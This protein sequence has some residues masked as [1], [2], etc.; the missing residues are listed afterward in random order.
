MTDAAAPALVLRNRMIVARDGVR[1]A[2]DVYLPP[3]GGG[4]WPVLLERTPYGKTVDSNF[5]H[6]AADKTLMNRAQVA[7][8]FVDHGYAVAYQ[9]CRGRYDS[10]GVFVKYVNEPNDGYDTCAWLVAQDW[11]KGRIGTFGLSYAAHT[12]VHLASA[13]APGLAAMVVDSGGFSNAYQGGV[14]Q[15]GAYELKQAL[16]CFTNAQKSPEIMADPQRLA[17]LQQQDMRAWLQD[18]PWRR[19]RSPV[20]LAPEYE[21]YLFAQWERGAF[22]DYWRQIAFWGEGFHDRFRGVPALFISGHYDIYARAATD[23]YRGLKRGAGAGKVQLVLGPW[24]HGG[25]SFTHSGDADFGAAATLDNNLADDFLQLRLRWFDRWLRDVP[26]TPDGELPVK[27]FVMGGGSGCR[28]AQG[29]LDHGGHWRAEQDWPIPRTQWTAYFLQPQGGLAGAGAPEEAG[30]DGYAYDP[31]KPVPTIG[32]AVANGEPYMF[33]GGFDQRESEATFAAEPP[34]RALADRADVLV[35]RTAPLT[36]DIEV[37]GP[38]KAKLWITSDCLDTDFTV[39]LIDEYPANADYPDGYALNVADGIIRARYRQSWERPVL[40]TPG[41]VSE[42]EIETFPTSNLFCAGHCIRV[43]IS[44]SNYPHFD[45]NPNTGER[46]G[47]ATHLNLARNAVHF[48]GARP[49]CVLLPVILGR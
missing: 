37:S 47:G 49:S 35:F 30:C 17:A 28:T 48:G 39:K 10:E 41:E 36:H 26:A 9:D 33:Q 23:N 8:Y 46:E 42:V 4:P 19:G 6:T 38:V 27:V 1:L 14:R 32:G 43:D 2:T 11:C 40:L 44:S 16:W 24:T 20:S 29:R 15:G 12:Q 45:A 34:Y 22:D 3:Q 18:M 25:R 21:E 13:G 5:E 31:R 7:Q